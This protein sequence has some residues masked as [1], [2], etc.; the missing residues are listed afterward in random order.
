LVGSW[1]ARHRTFDLAIIDAALPRW[2]GLIISEIAAANHTPTLLL[3]GHPAN[4]K[5]LKRFDYPYL[6]K[7]FSLT[8][9]LAASRE[10]IGEARANISRVSESTKRLKASSK[11]LADTMEISRRLIAVSKAT[12]AGANNTQ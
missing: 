2:S 1:R 4:E 7:P 3:S 6:R 12:V 8:E 10:V 11:A 5:Q 9:L